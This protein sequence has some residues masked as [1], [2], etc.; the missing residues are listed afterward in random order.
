MGTLSVATDNSTFA[1]PT[2]SGAIIATTGIYPS[3]N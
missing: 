3:R 2:V 1:L